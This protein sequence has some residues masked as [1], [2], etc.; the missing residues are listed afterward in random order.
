MRENVFLHSEDLNLSFVYINLL[1]NSICPFIL[2]NGSITSQDLIVKRWNY[3]NSLAVQWFRL[4]ASSI[5]A[6]VPWILQATE[7]SP[8]FHP[9]KGKKKKKVERSSETVGND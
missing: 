6:Q 7:C 2:W 4:H 8:P 5:G 9:S 3:W 1:W